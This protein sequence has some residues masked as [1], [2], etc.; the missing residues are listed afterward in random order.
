MTVE[1]DHE[2]IQQ[3]RLRRYYRLTDAGRRELAVDAARQAANSRAAAFALAGPAE[4]VGRAVGMR[5]LEERYR[6]LSRLLP[7][8]YREQW[9]DDMVATYLERLNVDD[10]SDRVEH[11]LE[12]GHVRW[13]E[14]WSVLALGRVS[15][16]FG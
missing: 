15:W 7:V 11:E 3:G 4:G 6:S 14:A 10:D 12:W 5:R 9:A 13:S 8:S 1:F 16:I 2:E